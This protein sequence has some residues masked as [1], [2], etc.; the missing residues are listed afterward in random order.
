MNIAGGSFLIAG[1][2]AWGEKGECWRR[3]VTL[4]LLEIRAIA[5]LCDRNPLTTQG[6]IRF[7]APRCPDSSVGRAGD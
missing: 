3:K 6:Q 7:N 2:G 4:P 1:F 5:R